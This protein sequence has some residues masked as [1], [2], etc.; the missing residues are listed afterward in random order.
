MTKIAQLRANLAVLLAEHDDHD[1][2]PTSAR[3]LYYELEQRDQGYTVHH[4]PGSTSKRR[5][6]QYVSEVLMELRLAGQIP[7]EWIADETRVLDSWITA[8]TVAQW[9]IDALDRARIDPWGDKPPLIVC[10]SRSLAGVLRPIAQRYAVPI[11]STNGQ[12]GGFLRTDLAPNMQTGQ[13]VIYLGDYNR[14]GADIEANTANVLEAAVG[15]LT[16]E[17]LALTAAQIEEYNPPAKWKVDG[18]DGRTGDTYEAEALGQT[19]LV[20]ILRRHLD[21]LLPEPLAAVQ[22]RERA[23]RDAVRRRLSD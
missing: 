3:F 9:S 2:I 13:Q 22:V 6:D 20:A 5:P 21:R 17:R 11:A 16:W 7:W 19:E 12:C 15:G 14:A 18:R 4:K 10:E 8:R 1:E 23:E